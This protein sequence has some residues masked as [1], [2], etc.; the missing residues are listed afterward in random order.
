[1]MLTGTSDVVRVVTTT[2]A[3]VDVSAN[4]ID[5]TSSSVTPGRTITNISSAATTTIVGSPAS[6]TQRG[7]TSVVILN[8]HATDAN[9][10]TVEHY[11]GTNASRCWKGTLAA[12]ESVQYNGRAWLTDPVIAT[13]PQGPQGAAGPQ[14]STGSDGWTYAYLGTDF[15]TTSATA[16]NVTG[17]AFTPA[18]NKNYTVE[19]VFLLRTNTTTVGPRPGCS[20][21]TGLTDGV[22]RFDTPASATANAIVMGN[23]NAAVLAAVGG[24]PNTTQSYPGMMWGAIV[25][26]ASPSGDF[27]IQLATETAATAVYMKAGSFIRWR[28]YQ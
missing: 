7:V 10:V 6:S 28:E 24:L 23:F 17:L 18:A 16:V 27:Q 14:G 26:G 12:G 19:G 13:G 9:T 8:K 11:D 3:N 2:S 4:W 21:P 25:S 1:M 20:W 22:V 15:N 5:K